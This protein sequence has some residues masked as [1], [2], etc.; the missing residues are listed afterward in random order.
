MTRREA[1]SALCACALAA[2]ALGCGTSHLYARGPLHTL[3]AL[4]PGGRASVANP[5]LA[6]ELAILAASG[7]YELLPPGQAEQV[8]RLEPSF[9]VSPCGMPIVLTIVTFGLIPATAPYGSRF[10]YTV[11]A[12][13][14]SVDAHEFVLRADERISPFQY[15]MTPFH[16]D[17]ATLGEILASEYAVGNELP[18]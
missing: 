8:I 15:L 10:T 2:L 17:T 5:E 16:D 1:R 4:H 12:A 7:I 11:A 18:R 3:P 14:G 6:E 9:P 13:D